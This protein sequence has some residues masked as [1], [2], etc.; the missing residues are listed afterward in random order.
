MYSPHMAEHSFRIFRRAK[1]TEL[2]LEWQPKLRVSITKPGAGEFLPERFSSLEKAR[3]FCQSQFTAK[4]GAL[5]C[6]LEGDTIIDLVVD[7]A[8]RAAEKRRQARWDG[9]L[10]LTL[11]VAVTLWAFLAH[12]PFASP[13]ANWISA[14]VVFSLY[15]L[16]SLRPIVYGHSNFEHIVLTVLLAVLVGLFVP[17]FSKA[18]L[19]A[20]RL[21]HNPPAA[22]VP[23]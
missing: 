11:F 18:R 7:F 8:Y 9:L 4:P 5:F 1:D 19:K 21:R 2:K 12:P 13:T 15:L 20:E 16:F 17:V 10:S 6:I 22:A 23:R 14:L 3:A